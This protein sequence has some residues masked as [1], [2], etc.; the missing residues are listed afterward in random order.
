MWFSEVNGPWQSI[1]PWAV[2]LMRYGF[3]WGAGC[4]RR[5]IGIISLPCES[6]GAGLV[7][8]GAIRYR[9][10][11]AE[12]NDA[13]TH[14]ER[15]QALAVQQAG[16]TC[17]RHQSMRGGFRLDGRDQQGWVWAR[18]EQTTAAARFTRNGPPRV[19]IHAGNA[20][21]WRLEG[22]APAEI[23]RGSGLP[24]RRFYEELVEGAAVPLEPNL[25]GSDS[26]ICFAGRI[27]GESASRSA[28]SAIRLKCHGHVADLAELLTV[29]RWSPDTVS[30]VTF[31][32]SRA[33]QLD[34][35]TGSTSLVVADG[36]SAFLRAIDAREFQQSDVVGVI[37]RTVERD[38]LESIGTK[39]ADLSQWY[40]PDGNVLD[41]VPQ[42]RGITVSVLQGRR[43]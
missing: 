32:N 20:N 39:L 3:S 14:F 13:L 2:Y 33:R 9:L 40:V 22:E 6:A 41:P 31:F 38:R 28:L 37:H 43:S 36:D 15:I 27:S 18:Q 23:V 21:E 5:R 12:A 42:P 11:L 16:E 10:T 7:A 25:A 35:N 26:A 8:L 17:L 24:H 30:R 34:R 19:G 29:H 1:P 4:G